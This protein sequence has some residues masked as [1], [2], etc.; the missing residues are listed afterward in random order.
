MSPKTSNS[1]ASRAVTP[2]FHSMRILNQ[3]QTGTLNPSK[4][5][6][7]ILLLRSFPIKPRYQRPFVPLREGLKSQWDLQILGSEDDHPSEE[8][9]DT[10]DNVSHKARFISSQLGSVLKPTASG[11]YPDPEYKIQAAFIFF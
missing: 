10:H 8:Q 5:R 7:P 2:S 1:E 4:Q 3:I 11:G 9:K 6:W